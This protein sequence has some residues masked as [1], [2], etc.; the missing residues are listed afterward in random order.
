MPEDST[1]LLTLVNRPPDETICSEP[2]SWKDENP[3][4]LH[5]RGERTSIT[6]H[7]ATGTTEGCRTPVPLG[8]TNAGQMPL[9]QSLQDS[10]ERKRKEN[11][12]TGSRQP[13]PWALRFLLSQSCHLPCNKLI[14]T[15][16]F[17]SKIQSGL[18]GSSGNQHFSVNCFCSNVMEWDCSCHYFK[19][20]EATWSPISLAA[21]IYRPY[22]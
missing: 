4:T 11:V 20:F 3:T 15:V 6:Q 18:P 14:F 17:A 19:W 12:F 10:S 8:N 21:F 9:L 22:T 2:Y 13:S 16:H 7:R 1:E 5:Q